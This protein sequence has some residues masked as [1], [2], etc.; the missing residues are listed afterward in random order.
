MSDTGTGRARGSSG[1][2]IPNTIHYAYQSMVDDAG[3]PDCY[4][5]YDTLA[6]ENGVHPYT[7]DKVMGSFKTGKDVGQIIPDLNM[8]VRRLEGVVRAGRPSGSLSQDYRLN[9]IEVRMN[10]L[11]TWANGTGHFGTPPAAVATVSYTEQNF[12]DAG[13]PA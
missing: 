9:A 2:L 6:P 5:Y 11:E 7:F 8:R 3:N 4:I 12:I 13:D 10:A 1:W